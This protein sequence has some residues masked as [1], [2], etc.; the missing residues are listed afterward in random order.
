[1]RNE[2]FYLL[3]HGNVIRD[4]FLLQESKLYGI[5]FEYHIDG[6]YKRWYIKRPSNPLFTVE[7]KESMLDEIF[8]KNANYSHQKDFKNQYLIGEVPFQSGYYSP[9]I[10]R[11]IYAFD[12]DSFI[13]DKVAD[14]HAE[15]MQLRDYLPIHYENALAGV[16]QLSLLINELKNICRTVHPSPQNFNVYGNEIRNVFILTCT[17]V[18]AQ[19]RGIFNANRRIPKE[20]T[21]MKDYSL[22]NEHLRLGAY[23]VFFNLYP[24]LDWYTPFESWGLDAPESTLPWYQAYNKVKH[25]REGEFNQANLHNLLNAI[26]GLAVILIA[27]YGERI[28]LWRDLIGQF[29]SFPSQ[30]GWDVHEHYLP[31]HIGEEWIENRV[32]AK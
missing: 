25:D 17:E 11:P 18:E 30:P 22:L 26:A 21:T 4:L 29:L 13:V 24:W 2:Q 5:F 31:P 9:R 10:Y 6:V 12:S 1:M 3:T 23:N 14:L 20:K 8:E 7:N 27:Q 16:T 15:V 28:P 32:F 19:L